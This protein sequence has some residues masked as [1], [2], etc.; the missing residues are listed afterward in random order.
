M[1]IVLHRA[2]RRKVKKLRLNFLIKGSTT[3]TKS[4]FEKITLTWFLP[5]DIVEMLPTPKT[6]TKY[7]NND[8]SLTFTLEAKRI[9]IVLLTKALVFCCIVFV[10]LYQN[11]H[12]RQ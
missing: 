9:L 4:C 12:H 3:V 2:K 5:P 11:N 1:Q 7:S 8:L 6:L 10:L